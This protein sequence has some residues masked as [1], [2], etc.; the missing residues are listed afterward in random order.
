MSDAVRVDAQRPADREDVDRLHCLHR[1]P[2]PIEQLLDLR[3][4]GTALRAQDLVGLVQPE[5]V[6][7]PHVEDQTVPG[8]R[9]TAH[10]VP[11][12]RCRHLEL[13]V[14]SELQGATDVIRARDP[15][16]PVDRR[17]VEAARVI[18]RSAAPDDRKAGGL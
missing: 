1:Q 3:P 15:D 10:A 18:D 8:E 6:H 17:L 5:P 16:D 7:A 9:L 14:A 12:A 11:L 4:G 2:L 13:P